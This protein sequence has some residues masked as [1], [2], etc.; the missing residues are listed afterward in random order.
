MTI[1]TSLSEVTVEGNG[2]T[3]A[4]T[5]P[6]LMPDASDAVIAY[7]A[8]ATTAPVYLSPTQYNISGIGNPAGGV[9]TYPISGPPIALGSFLVIQRILPLVQTTTVSNQGPTF[10][11]IEGALDTLEMQIQQLETQI[12][13][14]L[15]PVLPSGPVQVIANIATLRANITAAVAV[16][17][18]E[19]YNT[20]QDGGEG[21]FELISTDH[22]SADNGGTII[23]DASGQ[24]FYRQLTSS[25]IVAIQQF[26]AKVDGSTDDSAAIQAAINWLE[27][28]TAGPAGY[29]Q[30][31]IVLF[32]PGTCLINTGVSISTG[33]VT[34]QGV[35]WEEYSGLQGSHTPGQIGTHGSFILTTMTATSP[36]IITATANHCA[37]RG[38]A[39]SQSQPADAPGWA[40][41]VYPPTILAAGNASSGGAVLLERLFC[42][43]CYSFIQIGQVG[44]PVGRAR[45]KHI[46][47]MPIAHGITVQYSDDVMQVNDV[48]FWQFDQNVPNIIAWIQA[49]GVVLH[50]LRNDNMMISDVFAYGYDVGFLFE[51][52]VDGDSY[53]IIGNNITFDST[54]EGMQWATA[55]VNTSAQFTNIYHQGP[56]NGTSG[57]GNTA[58][59]TIQ[60]NATAGPV[61]L[62]ICNLRSV[63]VGGSAVNVYG[64][65]SDVAII[66]LWANNWNTSNNNNA[67]VLAGGTNAVITLGGRFRCDGG[68]GGNQ[69]QT[70]ET[71]V[72]NYSHVN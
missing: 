22:S 39:F 68:F 70:V 49:N 69:V 7:L 1:G 4:F 59:N 26:G 34:L 8:T 54:N 33:G 50:S 9:V 5:Y 10:A 67:A 48:H 28:G 53:G 32:P 65:D 3:T 12:I 71:G 30:G 24:R 17:Y 2:V 62:D 56:G 42:W 47:G 45:L 52:S 40:P 37:I 19:G 36:I 20:P 15:Q 60:I 16:V 23:V 31:G 18:V 51:S 27:T 72:V 25:G 58:F 57:S 38:I 6:F 14:P 13:T 64:T 11:A 61:R 44:L 35:G 63:N 46:W 55:G 41:N 29:G 21:L 43:N 66:N